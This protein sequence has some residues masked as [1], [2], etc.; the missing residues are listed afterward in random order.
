MGTIEETV[1]IA[2]PVRTAYNQWTQF[3]VFPRFVSAVRGVEQIKPTLTRWE[4]GLGPV[5]REF[6]TEVVE[7][8]PDTEVRWRVLGTRVRGA[9]LFAP[10][11]PDRTS[12]TVRIGPGDPLG[13]TRRVL[14]AELGHFKEFIEGLGEES[15]AWRGTVR[16]GRVRPAENR[17]DR[18]LV[19]HWPHG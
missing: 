8:R 11:T 17:P 9:A 1:E 12:L 13:I 2:V 5:S 14:G 18:S 10:L 15:G 7:Q 6:L 16:D 4:I 19:P 3:K